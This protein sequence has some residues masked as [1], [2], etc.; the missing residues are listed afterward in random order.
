MTNLQKISIIGAGKVGRTLARAMKEAGYEIGV[1][2][3]RN[4]ESAKAAK[5]F[6]GVGLPET[7]VLRALD[8]SFVH[9]ITTTDLA[10]ASIV[11]E[12]DSKGPASLDG[13]YFY[14]TSGAISSTVLDPLKKKGAQIGSIHPLQVFAHPDKAIETLPGI[15]YAIEG[16]DKAMELAVQIVARLQG[17]LLLIPTGRKVLYHIAGVFAANYLTV[18]V[19][20]AM[21]IMEEIGESPEDAYQALLPLMVGALQNIEEFGTDMAL[22]GPVSRG[23][24]ETIQKHVEAM[25]LLRPE[26]PRAYSVL[27]EE[28]VEMSVRGGKI[29]AEK[30]KQLLRILAEAEKET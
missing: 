30:A 10:I 22:T 13:H 28:A 19:E 16:T 29:S 8:S 20:L 2:V 15:Y 9:F 27:G 18:L 6:I 5:A 12:I 21:S 14:H 3:C 4:L 17:K 25:K 23:D 1:V 7:N 26:I 24:T 11:K